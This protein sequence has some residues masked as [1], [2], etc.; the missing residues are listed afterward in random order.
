MFYNFQ[1]IRKW[2]DQRRMQDFNAYVVYNS[3]LLFITLIIF[4]SSQLHLK[5]SNIW[6]YTEIKI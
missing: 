6:T 1:I 4:N 5:I 2:N 3:I